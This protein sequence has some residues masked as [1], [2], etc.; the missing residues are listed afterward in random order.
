MVADKLGRKLKGKEAELTRLLNE[1]KHLRN[2]Q[3]ELLSKLEQKQALGREKVEQDMQESGEATVYGSPTTNN[4]LRV[5][6]EKNK[7]GKGETQK[8]EE[9]F[10]L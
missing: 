2:E 6:E 4:E 10:Q 7:A 3:R 1:K 9:K 5:K 8:D